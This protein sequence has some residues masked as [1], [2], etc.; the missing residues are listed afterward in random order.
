MSGFGLALNL[1]VKNLNLNFLVQINRPHSPTGD[2]FKFMNHSEQKLSLLKKKTLLCFLVHLHTHRCYQNLIIWF[3]VKHFYSDFFNWHLLLMFN[4][5]RV[6]QLTTV[7]I[8]LICIAS[9]VQYFSSVMF[10]LKAEEK[11]IIILVKIYSLAVL[12][13]II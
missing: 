11:Q 9:F 12:L 10:R 1:Q 13:P 5:E 2:V 8:W 4:I 3:R 6:M 7:G